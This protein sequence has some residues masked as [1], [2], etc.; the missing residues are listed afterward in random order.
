MSAA[1]AQ[2]G[3]AAPVSLPAPIL[4][5]GMP[6]M[7]AL[8]ARRSTRAFARR[9]L[10]PQTLSN[11]LWAAFGVNRPDSGGRTAPSAH[12]AQEIDV[13]VVLEEGAY[14]Y[15]AQRHTLEPLT[16]GDLRAR[17]GQQD[18]VGSAPL[19]LVFVADYGRMGGGSDRDKRFLAACDTGF[20]SQNVYLACA[21]Q[22]L[23]T[24]VR[25]WVDRAALS[26]ALALRHEQEI[27]LAQ[28]IG[29]PAG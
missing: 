24:V 22:G 15:Q 8:Q 20:I 7:Q 25:G 3:Q 27:I 16:G 29:Y 11:L 14:V 9:K 1:T 6:L 2:A 17:T 26:K 28:T 13:L 21:A 19:D 4:E 5:G 18:F 12:G 23:A 10:A